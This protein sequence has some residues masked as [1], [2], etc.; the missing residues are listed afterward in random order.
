[1]LDKAPAM[2]S[3]VGGGESSDAWHMSSPHPE[4]IG[5]RDAMIQAISAAGLK[6]AEIG[7]VNA[8]GTGTAA[9]DGSE[10][11][12][13]RDVFGPRAVPVSSTKGITGHALGAA[14]IVDAIVAI[15]A[16]EHQTLPG[17]PTLVSPDSAL[18]LDIVISPVPTASASR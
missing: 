15:L 17:S 8:H 5:A 12:A 13:M 3:L 4:G 6:P 14:G 18:A 10:A 1:M 2:V 9:N 11:A 16:L 7:Y